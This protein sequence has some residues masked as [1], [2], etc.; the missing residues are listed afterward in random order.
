MIEAFEALMLPGVP[1]ETVRAALEAADGGELASGKFASL[2]SSSR[3]A[4]NAFGWFIDRPAA[5]RLPDVEEAAETVAVERVLR[6]PW[7]GGRHPNLDAV[8]ET[9][10]LL[11]GVES[12]RY[13]PF[14]AR[15]GSVELSEA[16]DRPVWGLGMAGFE[17]AK[18]AARE[19]RFARLD[20][21]Q[22]VK[23]ALGLLTQGEK[24]GKT[25]LLLYVYAEPRAWSDGRDLSRDAVEEHRTELTRFAE[26]VAGDAV[27][28]SAASYRN[29]LAF[30]TASGD[31]DVASHAA[32]VL[33][34]F[35]V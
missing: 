6:L 27:R 18:S 5:L 24:L 15:K 13:E 34:H 25:P 3:L 20:A 19:G 12:K 4:V 23:H 10:S 33:E 26:M 7:S 35:D 29:L 22:L 2:E 30:W 9:R 11:I 31:E 16:Y 14:R 17:R 28:F 32:R 21:A 8:A 1:S